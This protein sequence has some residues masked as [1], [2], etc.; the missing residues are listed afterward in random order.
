MSRRATVTR[1]TA[2]TQVTVEVALDGRGHHD[3][4]TP[5]PFLTH[6][7]TQVARHGGFD[8]RVEAKG[9]TWID[10][11]HTVEDV[12]L[13]LGGAILKA[14]GDRKGLE[15]FGSMRA[16]LDEALLEATIDLSGRP[17]LVFDIAL[18]KAKVGTFDVELTKEFF[19]AFAVEARCNLHLR[20]ISGQN[21]HH[22]IEATFK[23]FTL[24]LR[25]A[26]RITR[27]VDVLPSTKEH[28]DG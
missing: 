10:D 8:L 24:A 13:C 15:R 27:P 4:E 17:Y 6:M 1:M 3:I 20:A 11:H 25:N 9:D 14:L 23:A 22:L 21:L 19:Q 12:G 2:E 26:T 16:P 18:P 5:V 7:L 28:L